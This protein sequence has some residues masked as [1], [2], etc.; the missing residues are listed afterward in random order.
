[1]NEVA[2]IATGLYGEPL[3]KQN[4]APIRLVVPWKYGFKSIKSIVKLTF[5]DKQPQTFWN[6]AAP[7]EYS[8]TANV[9]PEIPH[10]RWSQEFETMIDTGDRRRTIKYNGYG[11]YVAHLYK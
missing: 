1:M 11:N 6:S 9:N 4:G 3:P 7:Q 10:L 2:F 8:I 5:T